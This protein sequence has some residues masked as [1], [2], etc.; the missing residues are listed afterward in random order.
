MK[1]ILNI[2]LV[3]SSL[4]VFSQTSDEKLMLIEINKVRY[5]PTSYIKIIEDFKKMKTDTTISGLRITL[6]SNTDWVKVCDETINFL[7]TVNPVDTL[8]FDKE[9]YIKLTNYNFV[10][11]HTHLND[12]ENIVSS[13]SV[14]EGLIS[15][16]GS[17]SHRKNLMN[18]KAKKASVKKYVYNNKTYFVQGFTH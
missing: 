6:K 12:S 7:K 1:M 3:L 17:I 15:L 4:T 8:S 11:E 18:P 16:L 5:S 2:L 9:A 14:T 10:G 13:N